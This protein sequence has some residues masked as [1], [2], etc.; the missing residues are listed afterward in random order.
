[1]GVQNYFLWFDLFSLYI[2][3]IPDFVVPYVF[4][5]SAVLFPS[6]FAFVLMCNPR[7]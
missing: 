4:V 1:M 6:G 7:N 3:V 2:A 5:L